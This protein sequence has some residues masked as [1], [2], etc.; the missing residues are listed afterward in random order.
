M[1]VVAEVLAVAGG[2]IVV[3]EPWLAFEVSIA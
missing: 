3:S 1:A 2:S